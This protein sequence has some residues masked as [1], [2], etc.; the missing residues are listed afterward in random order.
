MADGNGV[1]T[2]IVFGD[3]IGV[4]AQ[5][6][7]GIDQDEAM[8]RVGAA[9][10]EVRRKIAN[11]HG[12]LGGRDVVLSSGTSND[13]SKIEDVREQLALLKQHGAG[14]IFLLGVSSQNDRYS[15]DNEKLQAMAADAGATFVPIPDTS[16]DP[17]NVHPPVGALHKAILA[18]QEGEGPQ[19]R[20]LVYR[21]NGSQPKPPLHDLVYHAPEG[22]MQQ[23]KTEFGGDTPPA[24]NGELPSMSRAQVQEIQTLLKGVNAENGDNRYNIGTFGANHDGV[25]G[26]RG[27]FTTGAIQKYEATHHLGNASTEQLIADLKQNVQAHGEPAELPTSASTGTARGGFTSS[28]RKI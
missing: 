25:D 15:G 7:Y 27:G 6:G 2:P 16:G 3:S 28:L 19:V 17:M 23:F 18:A 12:D 22:Q 4:R 11:Y 21:Y 5:M 1:S 9:P 13:P 20:D 14:R 24:A 10:D 8:A 26:I